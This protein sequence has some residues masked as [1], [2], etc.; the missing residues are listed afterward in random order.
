MWAAVRKGW[1]N[2]TLLIAGGVLAALGSGACVYKLEAEDSLKRQFNQALNESCVD[3]KFL[4]KNGGALHSNAVTQD[5]ILFEATVTH[6]LGL[7]FDGPIA[8]RNLKKG[9]AVSVLEES[10]GP[11]KRYSRARS[12]KEGK[13]ISEGWYPGEFLAKV[14]PTI[15]TL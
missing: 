2:G 9:E 12:Y 14:E 7:M 8:L 15:T 5:P 11:D 6:A 3:E 1:S 13:P 10:L 4:A